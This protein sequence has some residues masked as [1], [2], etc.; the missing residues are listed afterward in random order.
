MN[1]GENPFSRYVVHYS[2][3]SKVE[4]TLRVAFERTSS[5]ISRS[6]HLDSIS[7]KAAKLAKKIKILKLITNKLI[8]KMMI[9]RIQLQVVSGSKMNLIALFLI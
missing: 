8:T 9:S 2:L 7:H 5:K 6:I 4:N 3:K 1:I